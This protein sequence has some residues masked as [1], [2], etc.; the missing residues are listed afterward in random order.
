MPDRVRVL[1]VD[2]DEGV[3][4]LAATVLERSIEAHRGIR[5]REDMTRKLNEVMAQLAP[6]KGP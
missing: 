6:R 1:V 5:A 3:L 4:R 2:D